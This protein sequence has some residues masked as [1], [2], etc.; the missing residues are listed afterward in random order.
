MNSYLDHL[1]CGWCGATY[2]TDQLI[3]LCPA[4]G[5]PLLARYDLPAARA[6]FDRDQ[7]VSRPPNLWRFAEV[8][9]VRSP[10]FRFTLGEGFTP[11]LPLARLGAAL[12]LSH[13]YAKDEGLNPD[14]L[15]Q[16]A[17][18]GSRGGAR[19]RTRRRSG[20]HPQRG[21]RRER[22]RRLAARAGIPAH[23]FLPRD[24]P[25]AFPGGDSGAR[26]AGDRWSTA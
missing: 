23:V 16:G 19:R 25:E 3:N 14:R 13:V 6:G 1:E 7:L 10:D 8:L 22:H 18:L 9:P 26:R 11:L 2:P 4:C 20:R 24:V 17:R 21:Q 5:K 12:G 15:V